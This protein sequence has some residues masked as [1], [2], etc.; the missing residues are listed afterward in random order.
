MKENNL[1]AEM[2]FKGIYK[3]YIWPTYSHFKI[4]L[5]FEKLYFFPEKFNLPHACNF[6]TET[7]V[8][9]LTL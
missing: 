5:F 2:I 9:P 3:G 6:E 7:Q 8:K 4:N 1:K